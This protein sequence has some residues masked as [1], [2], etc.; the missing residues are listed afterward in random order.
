[1]RD[2]AEVRRLMEAAITNGE[3]F[4]IVY[5]GGS[6]PGA[7]RRIA[8]IAVLS[9]GKIRARCY[10]S[11]AVKPFM[12][13]KI[14]II[15]GE[16]IAEAREWQ[17]KPAPLPFR[18]VRDVHAKY[19]EALRQKGWIVDLHAHDCG[20]QLCL[21]GHFK[22]GKPRKT[23]SHVLSYDHTTFEVALTSEGTMVPTDIRPRVRPWGYGGTY[24]DP[25]VPVTAFLKDAGVE[26]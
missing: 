26:P 24:A 6:N 2:V 23:P 8:P 11:N 16:R 1:M 15:S 19:E 10:T 20:W 12:L 7:R 5:H 22:N 21:R 13:E 17:A 4:D 3:W 18:D 25:T 9:G 14:E